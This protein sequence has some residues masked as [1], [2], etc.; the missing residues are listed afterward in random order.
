[1]LCVWTLLINIMKKYEKR[2][3]Q[4]APG[5]KSHLGAKCDTQNDHIH[6]GILTPIILEKSRA[7]LR[8][9]PLMGAHLAGR[10]RRRRRKKKTRK[11]TSWLKKLPDILPDLLPGPSRNLPGLDVF[12]KETT[13]RFFLNENTKIIKSAPS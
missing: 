13:Q 11:Q 9:A 2:Y 7:S 3:P 1:M 10:R 8:W 6:K 4:S 12:R 5:H